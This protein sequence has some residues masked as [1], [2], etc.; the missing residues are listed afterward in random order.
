MNEEIKL[1]VG[2]ESS[3]SVRALI[4]IKMAEVDCKVDVVSLVGEK[5]RLKT[6]SKTQLVPVLQHGTLAIPDSLAIAEY[7]N[8]YKSGELYPVETAQRA[9]ARS[10]CAELHSGFSNLRS[11]CSFTFKAVAR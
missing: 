1:L 7:L 11:Y 5:K 2:P 6:L 9:V 10:L 4:C 3:W 8:E